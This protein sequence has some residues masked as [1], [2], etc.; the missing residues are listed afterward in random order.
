MSLS[1]S[2]RR[3]ATVAAVLLAAGWLAACSSGKTP[4]RRFTKDDRCVGM[5]VH[6]RAAGPLVGHL[7]GGAIVAVPTGPLQA[8]KLSV[9]VDGV[10]RTVWRRM[11][12]VVNWYVPRG[13]ISAEQCQWTSPNRLAEGAWQPPPPEYGLDA[14]LWRRLF[15]GWSARRGLFTIGP[16]I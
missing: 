7:L 5:P 4:Y 13:V 1:H 16:P 6:T 9:V 8:I 15:G 2:L 11:A 10:E 12:Q 14:R 3:P